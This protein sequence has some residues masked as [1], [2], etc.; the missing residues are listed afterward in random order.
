MDRN[1]EGH[2]EISSVCPFGPPV[3]RSSGPPV[4][5]SSGP[6]SI[7]ISNPRSRAGSEIASM[8]A[9]LSPAKVNTNA[10]RRCPCGAITMPGLPFSSATRQNRAARAKWP[11]CATTALAPRTSRHSPS[12][13]P[14]F[15]MLTTTSGSSSVSSAAKSPSR[16]AVRNAS[17]TCRRRRRSALPAVPAPRT[18]R[19]A[20]LASWRAAVGE[21]PT[22]GAISSNGRSNMSCST[23]ARR[24][25][26]A[27][28]SSTVID[29]F[30]LELEVI[31]RA[32]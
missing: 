28:R 26:G 4:L 27:R 9:I 8:P 25:A 1:C 15:S 32:S 22:M 6:P 24:S 5:R 14:A 23:N 19:R 13:P 12:R 18:R 16:D 10:R 7:A 3:I 30:A 11:A 29:P 17:T 20:R 21:R 31:S 2:T